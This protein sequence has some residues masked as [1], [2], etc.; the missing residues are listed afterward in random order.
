MRLPH[1]KTGDKKDLTPVSKLPPSIIHNPIHVTAETI[2]KCIKLISN[3]F[4]T[5]FII[6]YRLFSSPLQ[7]YGSITECKRI[8]KYKSWHGRDFPDE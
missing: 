3:I 6:G 5:L 4:R 7:Q 8:I 2:A 1:T